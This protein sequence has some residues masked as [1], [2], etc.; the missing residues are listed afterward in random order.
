MTFDET[1]EALEG[2]AAEGVTVT[3]AV[4]GVG[5]EAAPLMFQTGLFRRVRADLE[6]EPFGAE[7]AVMFAFDDDYSH[8]FSLW[9]KRFED[10]A[11]DE[12]NG[13][14]ITTRDG[15]LRVYRNR[16]WID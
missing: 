9:P 5:P 8:T 11:V 1:I 10:G 15:R 3:A 12:V 7:T 4:W 2:L 13:I 16:P 14:S 6:T